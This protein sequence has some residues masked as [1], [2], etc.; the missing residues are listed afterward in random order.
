[1][2]DGMLCTLDGGSLG[3]QGISWQAVLSFIFTSSC[4]LSGFQVSHQLQTSWEAS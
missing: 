1:M 2:E 4:G 3:P